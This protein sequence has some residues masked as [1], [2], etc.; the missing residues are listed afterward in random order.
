MNVTRL[1]THLTSKRVDDPRT[2]GPDE[3]RL[4]LAVQRCH[5]LRD[6]ACLEATSQLVSERT[7]ADFICLR[8]ALCD[9]GNEANLVLNSFDDSVGG[10]RGWDVED[11]SIRLRFSDGL[12]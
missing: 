9:A 1:D 8:N 5:H 4:R 11:G 10:G 7:Y 12:V 6:V 3:A 2:V